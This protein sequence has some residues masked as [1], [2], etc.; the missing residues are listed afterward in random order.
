MP[1]AMHPH[2]VWS[3]QVAERGSMTTTKVPVGIY[4]ADAQTLEYDLARAAFLSS[5]EGD[6]FMF[7]VQRVLRGTLA[8]IIDVVVQAITDVVNVRPR[9]H[10][11]TRDLAYLQIDRTALV[12]IEGDSHSVQD[13]WSVEYRPIYVSG[14]GC[15]AHVKALRAQIEAIEDQSYHLPRIDWHYLTKHGRNKHS[16]QLKEPRLYRDE[17]YPWVPGGVTDYF[18]RFM[19]SEENILVLLGE[20]GTGKTSFLRNLIWYARWDSAFTYDE[21]LLATDDMFVDFLTSNVELLIVE[22]ADLFLT[23]RE[24]DGNRM[25]ARFLNVSDGLLRSNRVKKIIFTANLSA[26]AHRQRIAA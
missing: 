17:F 15:L 7:G 4:N 25:M 20:T 22:D 16:F 21:E 3:L 13:I 6:Y 12:K 24:H 11:R 1:S 10:V 23:N 19:E 2:N 5:F 8:T 26:P 14:F 18:D 9:I